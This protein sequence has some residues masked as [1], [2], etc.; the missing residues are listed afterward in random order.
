MGVND[1]IPNIKNY[2]IHVEDIEGQYDNELLPPKFV[3]EEISPYFIVAYSD[4]LSIWVLAIF[5]MLPILLLLTK[6]CKK[7]KVFESI[8]GG[9]FFNG[10]LRTI[11][12]MYFEMVIQVVVNTNFVKFRNRS[13]MIATA[14]AFFFGAFSLLLPF[15]LMTVIYANRKQVRKRVWKVKLGMLTDEL[16]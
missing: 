10:P 6:I 11:V 3:D 8:L 14:T 4:K 5:V 1:Y 15:I 13:Q 9:F 16:S 12:E 7:I 2:L